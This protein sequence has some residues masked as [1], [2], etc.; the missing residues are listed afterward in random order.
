MILLCQPDAT[1][2][3]WIEVPGQWTRNA[4]L[5]QTSLQFKTREDV[6][7]E[8]IHALFLNQKSSII[9]A[10]KLMPTATQNPHELCC[11]WHIHTYS[12][13]MRFWRLSPKICR[14]QA[15]TQEKSQWCRS[16]LS[17]SPKA[18]GDHCPSSKLISPYF[19]F[20]SIQA[21]NGLDESYPQWGGQFLSLGL[22]IQMLISSRNTRIDTWKNI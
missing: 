5:V 15:G 9:T 19:A 4:M 20:H 1:L 13:L 12:W 2:T 14:W 16:S 22:L 7:T 3:M 10:G 21:F 11:V 6:L 8:D 18:G 17:L